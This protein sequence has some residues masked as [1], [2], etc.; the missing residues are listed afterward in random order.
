MN[1]S[2]CHRVWEV[3]YILLTFQP[4]VNLFFIASCP[5][6]ASVPHYLFTFQIAEDLAMHTVVGYRQQVNQHNNL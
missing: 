6:T 5:K 3:Y 1:Y 4:F 2:G